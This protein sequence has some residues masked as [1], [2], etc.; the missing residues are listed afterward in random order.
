METPIYDFIKNYIRCKPCRMHMPG[1]KGQGFGDWLSAVYPLDLTEID[2]A[3]SLFEANGIIAQSEQNAAKLFGAE[4]TVYSAGGSTLC[5]QA[6]LAMMKQEGRTVLAARNVH[7][8]FLNACILLGL[9]VTWLYPETPDGILSGEITPRAVSRALT[10]AKG[11]VCVYLTSP[12]YLGRSADLAVIASVCKR[13]GA[14]LL[15]DNAHGAHLPFLAE[16]RHPMALGATLCCDSGHKTLPVL[17]GGAYLHSSSEHYTPERMKAAMALFAS[18]SPSYLILA[19]LD[20]CNRYL[21]LRARHDLFSVKLRLERLQRNLS[22]RFVFYGGD[23]M[24]LTICAPQSGFS[25]DGLAAQLRQLGVS[26]EYAEHD[27][28][29]LLASC[30][31]TSPDLDRLEQALSRCQPEFTPHAPLPAELAMPE[32][33]MNPRKAALSMSE[34]IPVEKALGRICAL[35]PSSC[36]PGVPIVASGEILT[37]SAIKLLQ[38]YGFFEI[39][40]VQ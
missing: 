39:H 7:R 8:S 12:D 10:E 19:S 37:E 29:V 16:N 18:T 11:Q 24:H 33:G 3:D 30:C 1:H 28:L 25:G 40:V 23:S 5:I 13:H 38:R 17:T 2:G 4:A 15:V 22:D 20:L 32:L 6:M 31:T 21:E 34:K 35:P 27:F 9:P 14:P 36:P 26:C